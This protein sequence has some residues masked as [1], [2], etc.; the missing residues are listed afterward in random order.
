[1]AHRAWCMALRSALC[2]LRNNTAI[3]RNNQLHITQGLQVVDITVYVIPRI[4][5]AADIP[6]MRSQ[7]MEH[8]NDCHRF[9]YHYLE[10]FIHCLI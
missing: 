2:A 7:R 5:H 9:R 8:G 3:N 6:L 10:V 1:M 4:I